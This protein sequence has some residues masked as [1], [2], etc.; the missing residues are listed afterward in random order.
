MFP[1]WLPLNLCAMGSG[2][3]RR[4]A[5]ATGLSLV[6]HVLALTGMVI[7]LKVVG[8]PPEDRAMEVRLV[9][10]LTKPQPRPE[11]AQRSPERPNP[12]T[13]LRPHLT[14]LPA[15]QASTVTLPQT[16][17]PAPAPAPQADAG[18]K[19][20]L[21][22]LSGRLGCDDP[23]T[24]HLTPEQRQTCDNR[25]AKLAREARPLAP[26][27]PDEKQADYDRHVRCQK[28]YRQAGVPPANQV[29]SG[30][31]AGDTPAPSQGIGPN[32][33]LNPGLGRVPKGCL[34]FGR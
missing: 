2:K 32:F 12:A 20:L 27:I 6:L 25:L 3:H 23:L 22:G 11:P 5:W 1:P 9:P 21:P 8:P 14:P 34:G 33:G 26:N 10:A 24:F 16:P 28:D 15:S 17:A 29:E 13:P 30:Q 19:G 18:P 31:L 4:A 7:G